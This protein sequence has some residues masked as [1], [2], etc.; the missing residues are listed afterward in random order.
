MVVPAS[1]MI[2]VLGMLLYVYAQLDLPDTPP[3]LQTTYL[4][5]RDGKQIAQLHSTV[6]RT[7]IS[8]NEMSK[9]LQHSVIAAEDN[10]FCAQALGFDIRTR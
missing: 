3:P 2:L 8:L 10:R 6:D 4:L 5:D 7:V 9:D 1:A